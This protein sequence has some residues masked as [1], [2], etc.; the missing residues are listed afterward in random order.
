MVIYFAS[1][2]GILNEIDDGEF[3]TTPV[4]SAAMGLGHSSGTSSVGCKT[5]K[6]PFLATFT[7]N[8]TGKLSFSLLRNL[9]RHKEVFA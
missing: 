5:R 4:I 1:I 3:F 2:T 9:L 7:A 6:L 8:V